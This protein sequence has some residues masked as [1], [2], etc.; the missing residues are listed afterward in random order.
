LKSP[1]GNT[2]KNNNN[3]HCFETHLL[4][5][6]VEQS[7]S[8]ISLRQELDKFWNVESIGTKTDSVVDQFENDIIHDG[9]RYITK[10]PFKPD[11]EVLP[12]NFKVCEGGLNH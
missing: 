11:H 10:L 2:S 6:S 7:E 8:D 9:T 5:A 1:A 12:D 4:R 3:M